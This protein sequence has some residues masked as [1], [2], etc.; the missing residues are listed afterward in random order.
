MKIDEKDRKI[1]S[2]MAK[3][4]DISQEAMATALKLSQPSVAARV[5]RLRKD[6]VLQKQVGI[7]PL[8]MGMY[9]AKVDLTSTNPSGIL[10]MFHGCPYF[11]NGFSVSGRHNLCLFFFSES[12]TTLEAIVNGHLRSNP[13]VS[14]VEFNIII[15]AENDFIVTS[16]LRPERAD[17]APC[18]IDLECSDCPS[19][20]EH[21]CNGC[22][23]TGQ[24][25]GEFY[26][27]SK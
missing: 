12:V 9:L 16:D 10:K 14:E 17:E 11:A 21:K 24:Y 25:C 20:K 8:K 22:P 18:G 27:T 4:P 7:N 3:D 6:G 5:A 2:M 15:S 19:F 13:T 1:V 26:C 23:V